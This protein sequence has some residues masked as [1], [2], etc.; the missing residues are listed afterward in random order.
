MLTKEKLHNLNQTILICLHFDVF[1]TWKPTFC[2][3]SIYSID[4]A[5]VLS[6]KTST[7]CSSQSAH[8]P[9]LVPA[10]GNFMNSFKYLSADINLYTF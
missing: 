10:F 5:V 1:L 4:G 3:D 6:T 9:S 7:E 2:H 8:G